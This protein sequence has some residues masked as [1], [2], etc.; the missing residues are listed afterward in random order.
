MNIQHGVA[1][2]INMQV[3]HADGTMTETGWFK[4][5]I[6]DTFFNRFAA[7]NTMLATNMTCVVGTGVTPPAN[8]DTSLASQ[9]ASI[10]ISSN[11]ETVGAI[12][13][14]NNRI[15][16]K[17][18]NQ[19]IAAVGAVV[20]N[21]SE[22]GFEFAPGTGGSNS[23]QLNSRSLTKDSFGAPTPITVTATDQLVV[24][25][26]FEVYIPL[27]DY[28][29]SVVINGTTHAVIGRVGSSYSSPPNSILRADFAGAS[30]ISYGSTSVFGAH[31]I[32]PTSASGTASSTS[33]LFTNITGGK[34]RTYTGSINQLNATGGIKVLSVP[35]STSVGYK[36]E[37]TPVIPKTTSFSLTL[38]LRFTC[39]RA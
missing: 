20:G 22:V 19:F 32:A 11:S 10:A 30:F 15:V 21:I 31:G 6:L 23:G 3:K 1:G 24:N 18:I 38:R 13:T 27:I 25:Y 17:S 16:A 39:V 8:S 37:F 4:N 9:V 14:P 36:Y 33:A 26:T 5:L 34:E 12:D 2:F 35:I 7:N 29:S 28:T